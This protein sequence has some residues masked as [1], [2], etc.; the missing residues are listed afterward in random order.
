L[1]RLPDRGHREQPRLEVLLL[2]AHPGADEHHLLDG[3]R[4]HGG[5]PVPDEPAV[6]DPDEAE[7][8]DPD[9]VHRRLDRAGLEGVGAV[10]EARGGLA[11]ED[12]VGDDGVEA[13]R[14]ERAEVRRPLPRGGRAEAV[15]EEQRVPRR[16]RG[17]PHVDGG[18]GGVRPRRERD[19]ERAEPRPHKAAAEAAVPRRGEAEGAPPPA[20]GRRRRGRHWWRPP[21]ISGRR[22]GRGAQ[23]RE[24]EELEERWRG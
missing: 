13:G 22:A 18:G 10:G 15:E 24:L 2:E 14:D 11:E 7:P 21:A 8:G 4:V 23:S 9:G 16:R 6:A 17:D 5:H 1:R 19:G 20:G 12:E 3:L